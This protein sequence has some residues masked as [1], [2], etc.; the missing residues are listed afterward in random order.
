MPVNSWKIAFR[1][2]VKKKEQKSL[3]LEISSFN[4]I[5]LIHQFIFLK[6]IKL[7]IEHIPKPG[8]RSVQ[9]SDLAGYKRHDWTAELT[10]AAWS[11]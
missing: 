8:N 3:G 4:S 6:S 10:L 2:K 11:W 7:A 1:E 5:S 9:I